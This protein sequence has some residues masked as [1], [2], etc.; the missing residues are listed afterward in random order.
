MSL[1]PQTPPVAPR[2]RAASPVTGTLI[3]SIL[4]RCMGAFCVVYGASSVPAVLSQ[5][6][7]PNAWKSLLLMLFFGSFGAMAVL[8]LLNRRFTIVAQFVTVAFVV[9]L[10]CWP[11]AAVHPGSVQPTHPWLWDLYSLAMAS[12]VFAFSSWIAAVYV[13][14]VPLLYIVVRMTPSGGGASLGLALL[15]SMYA[16]LLGVA[17][18][19]LATL[20]WRAAKAV[21]EAQAGAIERYGEA[22]REHAMEV[23]RVSVDAI[24][25]DGVLTT[26]LSAAKAVNRDAEILASEMAKLSMQRLADATEAPPVD[27]RPVSL[28]ALQ[29]RLVEELCRLDPDAAITPEHRIPAMLL[30]ADVAETLFSAAAQAL[31]NSCQHAGDG[32]SRSVRIRVIEGVTEIVV[33]DD[34]QGFDTSRPS[35]RLGVR[36]SILE[37]VTNIGGQASVRSRIGLGTSVTLR[38]T[39][40]TH[41]LSG[42]RA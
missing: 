41:V 36:V 8:G 6:T 5:H 7:L 37:R 26:L 3:A 20:L 30:P 34:G 24:I 14:V 2:R 18:F 27:D 42:L 15:D 33:V 35:E 23:E 1:T 4:R 16:F 22:V 11:W 13:T 40:E 39:S 19:T 31:V 29:K 28:V 10:V 21:D 38:W 17:I 12:S 32:A 25:H 9:A